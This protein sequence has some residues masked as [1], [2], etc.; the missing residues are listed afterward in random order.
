MN[1]YILLTIGAELEFIAEMS[2]LEGLYRVAGINKSEFLK[3]VEESKKKHDDLI[4]AI[5]EKIKEKEEK[6]W[7]NMGHSDRSDSSAN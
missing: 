3:G 7:E 4:A 5:A 1:D 6:N 2:R